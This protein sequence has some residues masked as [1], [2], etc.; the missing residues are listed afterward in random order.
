MRHVLITGA[1]QRL[2]LYITEYFLQCGW[3]VHAVT[4]H[5]SNALQA[6]NCDALN[7]YE[8]TDYTP[9][10]TVKFIEQ[11]KKNHSSLDLLINNASIYLP[12]TMPPPAS[13]LHETP[14]KGVY[15]HLETNVFYQKLVFIHMQL[16]A[17]LMNG[18]STLVEKAKGN[19]ISIT[20]IYTLNPNESYSLYCSTKA[21]LQNLTLSMAKK[22]A[23][24]VRANCILPGPIKFLDSHD[25]QHKTH[26]MKETLLSFEGGFDP[27]CK[28]IQFILDNT[29][30]TGECI[31]VDGGRSLIRA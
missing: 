24:N 27:I 18:L 1:S 4:R 14:T 23:P 6:L 16:P 30:I 3:Q 8:L 25:D 29:Y 22:L 20:D 2:G 11:F 21:G 7:I 10:N 28:T 13:S 26:V 12:D 5:A 17:L 31:K 9:D 15:A 19:L